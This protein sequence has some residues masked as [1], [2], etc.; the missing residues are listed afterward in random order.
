MK[1][2][3]NPGPGVGNLGDGRHSDLD[4]LLSGSYAVPQPQVLLTGV[5]IRLLSAAGFGERMGI[6][7]RHC[8][9]IM[10]W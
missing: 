9:G 4:P 8:T 3:E 1:N 7:V 10:I 2:F 6:T 5:Q